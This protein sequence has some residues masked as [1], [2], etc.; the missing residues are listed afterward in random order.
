MVLLYRDPHGRKSTVI[1]R[2]GRQSDSKP[3]NGIESG[4]VTEMEK[5]VASLEKTVQEGE[6]TIAELRKRIET[7]T[8]DKNN[9]QVGLQLV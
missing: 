9:I 7:L 6:S 3:S 5:K 1:H 2:G 4:R 8:K